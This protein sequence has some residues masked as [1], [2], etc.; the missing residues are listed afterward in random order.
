MSG[1][2][3]R[4]SK[5]MPS[6]SAKERA[7]LALRALNAGQDAPDVRRSMPAEQR[8]EYNRYMAL[9]FVAGCQMGALVHV[10]KIRSRTWSST[11]TAS[12][13]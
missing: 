11:S 10:I 3:G 8:H 2:A 7:V 9:A 12:T 5:L 1:R 6:L 4:L 13:C